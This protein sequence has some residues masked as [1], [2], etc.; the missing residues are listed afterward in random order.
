MWHERETDNGRHDCLVPVGARNLR[1]SPLGLSDPYCLVRHG[2][3]THRGNAH[4]SGG[5]QPAWGSTFK[6]PI[7]PATPREVIVEIFD[8]APSANNALMGGCLITLDVALQ[9]G[10]VDHWFDLF[11]QQGQHAGQIHLTLVFHNSAAPA[12]YPSVGPPAYGAVPNGPATPMT[13]VSTQFTGASTAS[14]APGPNGF[15]QDQKDPNLYN[16]TPQ[17]FNGT[18]PADGA[19]PL[20]PVG[21]A[22]SSAAPMPPGY[23]GPAPY[24]GAAPGGPAPYPGYQQQPHHGGS[25]QFATPHGKPL[26]QSGAFKAGAAGAAAGALLGGGVLAAGVGAFVGSKLQQHFKGKNKP[27]KH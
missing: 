14:G 2:T 26:M 8:E 6:L 4:R 10:F 18:G 15:P 27:P 19:R 23:G 22:S 21:P 7:N 11:D 25:S 12:G 24:P 5:T 17:P 20:H 16:A 3:S 9:A 1:P 13:G